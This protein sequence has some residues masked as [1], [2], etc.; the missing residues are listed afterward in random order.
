[1]ASF[2]F[3]RFYIHFQPSA[4]VVGAIPYLQIYDRCPLIVGF[5]ESLVVLSSAFVQTFIEMVINASP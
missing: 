1:M 3:I 2:T 5:L 4:V